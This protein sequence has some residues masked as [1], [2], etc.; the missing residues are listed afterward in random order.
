MGGPFTRSC[1]VYMANRRI[2]A[3]TKNA[4]LYLEVRYAR[5]TAHRFP[6]PVSLFRLKQNYKNLPSD[7]YSKNLEAYF[8]SNVSCKAE[9]AMVEFNQALDI[10]IN[11]E[12]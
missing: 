10:L 8:S 5:D 9:V 11:Q 2:D 1:D 3:D 12:N 4:R 7:T 6:K